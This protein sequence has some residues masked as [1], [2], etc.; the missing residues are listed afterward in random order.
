MSSVL[1]EVCQKQEGDLDEYLTTLVVYPLMNSAV[2]EVPY[3]SGAFD[4]G[5]W[6]ISYGINDERCPVAV[7]PIRIFVSFRETCVTR[8]SP[9]C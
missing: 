4:R 8:C 7:F 5:N 6:M 9:S 2:G 3:S 1:R